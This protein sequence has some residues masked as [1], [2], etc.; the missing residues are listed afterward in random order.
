M[1]ASVH[2]V[3]GGTGFIGSAIILELLRTTDARIVA[4][5]R[6]GAGDP[7]ARL[8]ETLHQVARLHGLGSK[9]DRAI[10][11]RCRALAGDVH[12]PNCGVEPQPDWDTVELW[13]CAA[14]LQFLDRF[15][16]EIF[17]TNVGGLRHVLA[18]A[19]AAGVETL[20][21]VST[22]YVAGTRSG[23]IAEAPVE[24]MVGG[25]NNHYERSKI[26]AELELAHAAIPCIRVLRPSIVIGHSQTLAALNFN[27]MYGFLRSI[28][29]F[30]R[31]LE[32][33]QRQLGDTMTLRMI[34]DEAATSNLIPVDL[35]AHDAVALSRCGAEPGYYHLTAGRPLA[36]VT[37]VETLFATV[38]MRS[39]IFVRDR[40]DF[41]SLDTRFNQRT[42]FY[43]A[44]LIGPKQFLRT[45]TDRYVVRSPSASFELDPRRLTEFSRWYVDG[46]LEQRR[47]Q[48]E[49][50]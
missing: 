37:V 35:V 18:L 26:E 6:P 21:V 28:Y 29:K 13:H 14:S 20:N 25:T 5:V 4:V 47:P 11:S 15:E 49:T 10:D 16:A 1:T 12:L 39:P 3:T 45:H 42:D 31:L 40:S 48:R 27:G 41:T 38:G 50:R 34:V 22:A 2:L 9:L 24:D 8:R 36:T 44:Y 46:V 30:R 33:T 43:N 19:E 17:K 7:G 23:E 32:R